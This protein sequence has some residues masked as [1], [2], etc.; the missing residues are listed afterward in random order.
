MP[1]TLLAGRPGNLTSEQEAKLK[2]L[3]IATLRVFGVA[4]L[5]DETNE[6]DNVE[7]ADRRSR[8]ETNGSEKKKKRTGLFG[9]KHK[10]DD[11]DGAVI[12]SSVNSNDKWGQTKDFQN[13][14]ANQSPEDLRKAFWSMVKHDNPDGLL[15]RFL[16]ARKWDVQNALIMMV[17]TLHWRL[18]E[19][20][21][22]DDIMSKGEGGALE[23]TKS[24]NA[25]L[26]KDGEDFLVQARMGKSYI[27]GTDKEGRPMCFVRVRL[28]RKGEQSEPSLER[29]TVFVIETARLMLAPPVD[30]AVIVFDMTGFSM[31]N[32]DY[33]PV[34]F[35]IK[36]FEANY[37]E[38]LGVVLVHN[39][40]WIF[41]EVGIWNIIKG[42]LD[43]VVASKVHFTRNVEE[44][45]AFVERN[46]I[47][48]E[49]GGGDPWQYE[50]VEPKL[51]ENDLMKDESTKQQLLTER[52]ELVKDFEKTT[53]EWIKGSQAVQQKRPELAERLRSGY[54]QLD[55][56]L[57]ARS[58]YDRTGIMGK[59]GKID[60]YGNFNLSSEPTTT[61]QDDPLPAQQG[62]KDLD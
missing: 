38:S 40:P 45:E 39:S 37:P 50:F 52:A 60:H 4:L 58:L 16:R 51:G 46:H 42:W 20:H 9:K 25:S 5:T 56:Y 23:E 44:L 29:Y 33:T 26:R 53:Q 31:A 15:L 14:I 3:W 2:E 41:H 24:S 21:V 35:I 10:H 7:E 30:T 8:A 27:H 55:P 18:Q 62:S 49:L 57:R 22:D 19:M 47:P 34:K 17:A 36:V 11:V 6:S 28:H 12:D 32:M 54:W 48:K 13:V 59:G 43:P 1:G 61:T